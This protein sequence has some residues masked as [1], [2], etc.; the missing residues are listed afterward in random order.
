MVYS[1][2]FTF[3]AN[4]NNPA[5]IGLAPSK[6]IYFGSLEFTANRFGNLSLSPEG[7][8]SGAIFIGIVHSGSPSLHTVLEESSD[9]SDAAL[10]RGGSLGFPGP[11]GC[12]V[13]TPT[14]PIATTPP[15]ENTLTLLTIVMVQLQTATLQ[16]GIGLL[17]Q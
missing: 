2:K 3:I 8:D 1:P 5:G 17:P 11:Q 9:E 4:G 15:P 13:V 10:G 14:I 7:E 16:P 12:N 6:M